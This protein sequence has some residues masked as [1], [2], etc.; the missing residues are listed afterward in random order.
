M[1]G[2]ASLIALA[3][4]RLT[5]LSRLALILGLGL[6]LAAILLIQPVHKAAP[7]LVPSRPAVVALDKGSPW[8]DR[9]LLEEGASLFMPLGQGE[10]RPIDVA[11]PDASPF[12]TFGPEFRHDPTKPLALPSDIE[13]QGRWTTLEQAFPF[14]EDNPFLTLGQ[15]PRAPD[16][17]PPKSRVLQIVSFS[18]INE[19]VFKRDIFSSDALIKEHKIL[20]INTL[21]IKSPVEMR[22]GVDA[23]GLQSKPYLLKSSGDVQWDQAVVEWAG[24]LPWVSWLKP[25]SY[26]VV[27]G[28]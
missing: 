28:P 21:H 2:P 27:I 24:E 20:T 5:R 11:Q 1:A 16:A 17:R 4:G 12:N 3:S 7:R 9:A 25:G 26:R 15:K 6:L 10:A 18:D 14:A 19:Y 22:L 23:Y 8:S 13:S